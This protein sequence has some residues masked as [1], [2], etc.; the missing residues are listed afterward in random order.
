MNQ[1]LQALKKN[2]T[3]KVVSL[4]AG[5]IP[6]GCKWVYKVKYKDDG[7]VDRYKAKLVAK[8][9]NK[10]EGVDFTDSFSPVAK[11]VTVR[12]FLAIAATRN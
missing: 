5:K 1:E 6:I 12:I 7:Y 2:G 9:Y 8:G 4:P 11:V 3:W 10:V